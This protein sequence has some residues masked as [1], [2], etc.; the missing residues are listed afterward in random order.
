MFSNLMFSQHDYG[1]A[2]NISTYYLGAQRCGNTDSWIHGA[3]HLQDGQQVGKD[4]TG[5]WHDC[6]DHI[7]FH[8]TGPFTAI[9]YLYGYDNFTE[10][11]ED[12]YSTAFSAPPSNGIP[13][14]LDEV[15][16]ETDYLIKC[17]S[18][19]TAYWQIGNNTD[20]NS[21]TEPVTQS[22][23]S[24]SNGGGS[25]IVY[26]TTSGHTNA[27]GNSAGALA[28]MSILYQPYNPSYA[29]QCLNA[30]E[31]YY[32][33]AKLSPTAT[34]DPDDYYG[35]TYGLATKDYDDEL[36]LAAAFLYRATA[37][38]NYLTE[39][40]Q[41]SSSFGNSWDNLY[42]GNVHPLLQVELY[43]LTNKASY[44]NSV[45]SKVNGFSLSSCGYYHSTNWGSLPFAGN[46]AF[47][48]AL[49]DKLN[50][51]PT[52][53]SFAKSNVD[54]ILGSHGHISNDAPANFSF[55]I[56][57]NELGGGYPLRPHHVSAFGKTSN[58]WTAFTNESNNPGSE[59]FAFEL[60]GGLAGGPESECGDFEDNIGN[61]VSSEYCIYYGAGFMGAL[62]AVNK[63]ENGL[64]TNSEKNPFINNEI[65]ISYLSNHRI[66][67]KTTSK[68][69]LTLLTVTGKQVNEFNFQ[70]NLELNLSSYDAG[71]Y[72]LRN[73]I[74]GRT[75][76][77]IKR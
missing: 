56:G 2:Q 59:T 33:I 37:N 40:E 51:T 73:N 15:K 44:L 1:K 19:A 47:L 36:G 65:T 31:Q 75:H 66:S 4:L 7:K 54:F 27:L 69:S 48:A 6:G 21:F 45:Q 62:A 55:L 57:Y 74:T 29:T 8:H 67:L 46:A 52:A 23:E 49:Y 16:V 18:N 11:Y 58:A 25:R 64:I 28:L 42:Y 26:S 34:N 43:K 71:I 53:Y 76:R 39:A 70:G 32:N 5:G 63:I 38:S 77:I 61:Y 50:N 41:Y 14:I 9:M 68:T 3:C 20:H 17:V 10:A 24:V 13:D 22:S 12:N 60:T 30:A 35:G 72:L